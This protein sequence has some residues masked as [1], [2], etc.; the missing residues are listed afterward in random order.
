ML[1]HNLEVL[2][3]VFA[4]LGHHLLFDAALVGVCIL[5]GS[6]ITCMMSPDEEHDCFFHRQVF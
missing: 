4:Y 1:S 2:Q 6:A 5:I 3:H